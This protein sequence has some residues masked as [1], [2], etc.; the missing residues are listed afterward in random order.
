MAPFLRALVASIAFY[1][2]TILWMVI[3]LPG[4]AL[5]RHLAWNIVLGWAKSSLWLTKVIA[6]ID[7]RIEGRENLPQGAAIVAPKHQSAWETFAVVPLLKSPVFILKK[8]LMWVPLFGWYLARFGSIPVDR[9]K[10]GAAL[11]AM[12]E[13]AV[14]ALEKGRQ[15]VIFPEGTRRPVGAEPR[16][17]FGVARIYAML[18]VPVVPV[19]LNSGLYWPRRKM[20]RYP[21]TVTVKVLPAIAPGHD[22]ETF[23]KELETA[24]E[25]ETD[26]LVAEGRARD[27]S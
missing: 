25:T 4:L 7:Y 21:G 14:D 17:K 2:N 11:R 26:R 19:A 23:L 20:R 15:I 16:Y 6:G 3:C 22:P 18:G 24:I 8:E 27:F 10:G 5:P 9:G 13:A 1:I 12:S